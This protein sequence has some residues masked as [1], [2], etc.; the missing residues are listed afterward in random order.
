MQGVK[1]RTDKSVSHQR[2]SANVCAHLGYKS[3][4]EM[5]VKAQLV[6]TIA[7]ILAE[8]AYTRTKAGRAIESPQSARLKDRPSDLSTPS[9]RVR[10]FL[11]PHQI[12]LT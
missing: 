7:E 9:A 2:G 3:A 5:L 6:T 4:D 10:G 1:T 12:V 11:G 8:R